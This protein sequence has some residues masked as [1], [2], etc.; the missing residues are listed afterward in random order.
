VTEV[1]DRLAGM[2]SDRQELSV[3]APRLGDHQA[4]VEN[5]P[6]VGVV[7]VAAVPLVASTRPRG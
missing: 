3:A 2:L 4:T 7:V 5:M 6:D 1:S